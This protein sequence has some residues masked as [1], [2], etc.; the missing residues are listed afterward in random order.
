MFA[1]SLQK[2][3]VVS[4][5]VLCGLIATPIMADW[6][7]VGQVNGVQ[8]YCDNSTG[9]EWTVSLSRTGSSG[10]A[11]QTVANL[12]FRLP[13][14][15][16]FRSLERGGGIQR[17]RIDTAWASG[18]YW[19][20]SGRIV[21]GN[22]GNFTSLFPSNRTRVGDP[23]A[24]GVRDGG[25]IQPP[26]DQPSTTSTVHLITVADVHSN[27]PLQHKKCPRIFFDY[28]VWS[29][30]QRTKCVL[31]SRERAIPKEHIGTH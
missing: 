15:S 7:N 24:I 4:V 5:L 13:T 2:N 29:R 21:N 31:H 17:L 11:Q 26:I 27:L 30:K 8:V 12:G 22:G 20:A 3:F 19:E 28:V 10:A 16:E 18:Y 25:S 6:T 9:L 14:H 1:N 23:Y